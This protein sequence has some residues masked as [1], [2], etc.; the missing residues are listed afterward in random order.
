MDQRDFQRLVRGKRRTGGELR[1][2]SS[3]AH[4]IGNPLRGNVIALGKKSIGARRDT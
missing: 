3:G 2:L 4:A 1:V